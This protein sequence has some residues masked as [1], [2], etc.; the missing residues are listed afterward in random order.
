MSNECGKSNEF[1][2]RFSTVRVIF[3]LCFLEFQGVKELGEE[4]IQTDFSVD[5][6]S[7]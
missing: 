2:R 1:G 4:T 6:M 7:L 5:L 3:K